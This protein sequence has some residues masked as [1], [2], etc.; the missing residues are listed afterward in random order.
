[1]VRDS[2]FVTAF[3]GWTDAF[4]RFVASKG[5]VEPSQWRAFGYEAPGH[6]WTDAKLKRRGLRM[7][8]GHSPDIHRQR[9]RSSLA[10]TTMPRCT[11][12]RA[13]EKNHGSDL[14][15]ITTFNRRSKSVSVCGSQPTLPR[16]CARVAANPGALSAD[17]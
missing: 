17:R 8:M 6:Q 11:G 4:A 5:K 12:R 15:G 9:R 3:D 13:R 1:M 7:S 16:R 14:A 10:S 2:P